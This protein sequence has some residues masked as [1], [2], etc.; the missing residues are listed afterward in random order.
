[1][2]LV[3]SC[4]HLVLFIGE[5]IFR[6]AGHVS[7]KR[8]NPRVAHGLQGS[9]SPTDRHF[10]T[11]QI[12]TVDKKELAERFCQQQK[13]AFSCVPLVET[14]EKQNITFSLLKMA[15]FQE[16]KS[17]LKIPK[18]PDHPISADICKIMEPKS[19]GKMW[20]GF[21]SAVKS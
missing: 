21:L 7:P 19:R 15:H 2:T 9:R 10:C 8:K 5:F 16:S 14:R 20:I 17:L 12:F 6:N 4:P 18:I 11:F 1:M 3:L 13:T